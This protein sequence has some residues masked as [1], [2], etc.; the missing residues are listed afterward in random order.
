MNTIGIRT[1]KGAPA[2]ALGFLLFF[3]LS[4]FCGALEE[5]SLSGKTGSLWV[6]ADGAA[7]YWYSGLSW[8]PFDQLHLE[9]AAGGLKSSLPWVK[10]DLS[11]FRFKTD[12]DFDRFG[13][14]VSGA[15]IGSDRFEL[16]IGD[17]QMYNEGGKANLFNFS[18]PLYLGP[19]VLNPSFLTGYGYLYD[20]SLYWFF[21]KPLVPSLY[22]YG[23]SAGYA[24]AH[25]LEFRYLG[26]EPEIRSNQE[27]GLFTARL[28]VF[29]ASYTLNLGPA[30]SKPEEGR[31]RFEGTAGWLYTEGSAEGALTASNQHYALFPFT[32]FSV[33]GSL[34]AHIAY[35]LLRLLFRPSI[36]QFDIT[37]GAAHVLLGEAKADYH[38]KMKRLFGGSEFDGEL[39]P[40]ELNNT[41]AAFL[42]LDGGIIL[43]NPYRPGPFI[44]T[45]GI[46]KALALPWGYEKFISAASPG[47]DS[48][49]GSPAMDPELLRSVLLSGLSLYA[50]ISR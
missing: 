44:V 25:I 5:L 9:A 18:L 48:G 13:V 3:A 15:L 4:P 21:G 10:T 12:V 6:E 30:A 43:R 20:G 24:G 2:L 17:A 23:L 39:D 50:R 19:F 38:F 26:A 28:N 29:L 41:G 32:F 45:L 22:S 46:Q 47:T 40:V 1:G 7:W 36:F 8:R 42:L 31:R 49:G 27:E 37:L 11:L 33:T 16:D 14:H 35:G 34:N